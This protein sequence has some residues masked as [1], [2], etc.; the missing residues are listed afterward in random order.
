MFE[1]IILVIVVAVSLYIV[2]NETKGIFGWLKSLILGLFRDANAMH[3]AAKETQVENPNIIKDVRDSLNNSILD[4][5]QY[6]KEARARSISA[7]GSY[8][9]ALKA[10]EF[11]AAEGISTTK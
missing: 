8:K 3:M 5:D 2:P 10:S 4:T 9:K 11:L 7:T 1:L 6:Y